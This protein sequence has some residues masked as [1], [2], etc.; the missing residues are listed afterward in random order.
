MSLPWTAVGG[1]LIFAPMAVEA[2]ASNRH[3]RRLR[4][5]GAI[6]PA[7]DVHALMRVAYPG[8]FLLMLA[9]AC[10]QQRVPIAAAM[11]GAVLFLAAKALKYAAIVALG[12]RWSFRL[13][14][15]PGV[16][17]IATGPYR[18]LSHP[19]Y[20]AVVGE[21]VGAALM[22]GAVRTGPVALA[23]FLPLLVARIRI[24]NAA[25]GRGTSS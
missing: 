7:G 12:D 9:E 25:L 23:V 8:V 14:V 20:V 5:R 18:L 22:L 16:P 6:E 24:E 17:L 13:L 3:E 4:A 19:N 2:R 11:A 15:L 1:L 21:L 10:W